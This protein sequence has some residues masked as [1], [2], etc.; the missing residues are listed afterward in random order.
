VF[1]RC[2]LREYQT[3]YSAT[4][5]LVQRSQWARQSVVDFETEFD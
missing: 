2:F 3:T 4:Q 5:N 1:E